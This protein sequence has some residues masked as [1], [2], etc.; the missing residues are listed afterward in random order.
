MLD[1]IM[2]H[3]IPE[4]LTLTFGP[5]DPNQNISLDLRNNA[6]SFFKKKNGTSQCYN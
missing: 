2:T 3:T 5:A 4:H 1:L 6:L